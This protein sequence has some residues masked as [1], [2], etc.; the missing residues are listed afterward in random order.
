MPARPKGLSGRSHSYESSTGFAGKSPTGVAHV[1]ASSFI[2]MAKI[3]PGGGGPK[4]EYHGLYCSP[5]QW[6]CAP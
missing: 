6:R 3:D 5:S 1:P 2:D 4:L